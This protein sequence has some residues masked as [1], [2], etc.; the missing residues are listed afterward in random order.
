MLA[1]QTIRHQLTFLDKKPAWAPP[2]WLA[3]IVLNLFT[4]CCAAFFCD[5]CLVPTARLELAQLSPL[6]PQDSVSTNFTTSAEDAHSNLFC[7]CCSMH[8][9]NQT[10]RK[11]EDPVFIL[12]SDSID[13][14]RQVQQVRLAQQ[15]SLA[16]PELMPLTSMAP[17]LPVPTSY[18]SRCRSRCC[19]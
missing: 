1:R 14:S 8:E 10:E 4:L 9:C 15:A 17:S 11:L 3:M 12:E 2:R 19:D 5:A 6:P 13:H 16:L 7:L 18:L